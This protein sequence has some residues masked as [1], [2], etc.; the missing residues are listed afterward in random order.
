MFCL[1]ATSPTR[2]H[3]IDR[4]R[5]GTIKKREA[6]L[7]ACLLGRFALLSRRSPCLRDAV[8]HNGQDHNRQPSL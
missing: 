3:S 4:Y 1:P 7:S 8:T 6:F 2:N 5:I